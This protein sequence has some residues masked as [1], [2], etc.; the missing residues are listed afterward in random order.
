M[1]ETSNNSF[2]P[3]T[4]NRT[5]VRKRGTR[6]YI[7]NYIS[8]TLF[9]IALAG[10]AGVYLYEYLAQNELQSAQ[11]EVANAKDRF[12]TS[13]ILTAQYFDE[14]LDTAWSLLETS[15]APSRIFT[16]LE[17]I[18]V[19]DVTFGE[20]SLTR[21]DTGVLELEITGS[22]D[23]FDAAIVQRDLIAAH[24]AFALNSVAEF[25]YGSREQQNTGT[26]TAGLFE[27]GGQS[28]VI[29][30]Y[31]AR[32]N[33][34]EIPYTPSAPRQTETFSESF[35]TNTATSSAET[36]TTSTD[37]NDAA[38]TVIDEVEGTASTDFNDSAEV[39]LD[40]GIIDEAATEAAADGQGDASVDNSGS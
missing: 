5:I 20:F 36:P 28:D 4:A 8:Y 13:D 15:I 40:S 16:A 24:R 17:G 33:E 14:R 19:D 21:T 25:Q 3:K 35:S 27:E 18:V 37:F 1:P 38:T 39:D 30:T 2:I 7:L 34:S 31:T 23:T 6:L 22:A 12:S 9:F 10:V 26:Q 32:M 11:Q 29:V